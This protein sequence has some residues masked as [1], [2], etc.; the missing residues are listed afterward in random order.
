[1]PEHAESSI[2]AVIINTE[3]RID[4]D[5]ANYVGRSYQHGRFFKLSCLV[6]CQI[7]VAANFTKTDSNA[8]VVG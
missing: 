3:N 8:D 2:T 5:H 7:R 6:D 4:M 1:M